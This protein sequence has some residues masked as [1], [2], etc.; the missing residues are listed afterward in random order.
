MDVLER[1]EKMGRMGAPVAFAAALILIALG[2]LIA[3]APDMG[4][5][6]YT[7]DRTIVLGSCIAIWSPIFVLLGVRSLTAQ[8]Y[9]AADAFP[10][11]SEAEFIDVIASGRLPLG[12]CTVC[13]ISIPG[14]YAT[15]T[16]PRCGSM[17]DWYEIHEEDDAKLVLAAMS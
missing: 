6:R 10:S 7:S 4:W 8:K 1:F 15:G 16:C 12:V 11:L 3:V 2:A 14:E 9:D 13:K 17:L 5:T